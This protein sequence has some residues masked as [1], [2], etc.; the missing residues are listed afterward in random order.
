MKKVY[1]SQNH[2]VQSNYVAAIAMAADARKKL[3]D[4]QKRWNSYNISVLSEKKALLQEF[5]E[6]LTI[7]KSLRIN[8]ML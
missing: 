5:N 2:K 6:M 1:T 3:I 4:G 7:A 8:A